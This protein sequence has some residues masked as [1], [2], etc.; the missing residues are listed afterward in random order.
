MGCSTVTHNRNLQEPKKIALK[1][2]PEDING[3]NDK[4][5]NSFNQFLKFHGAN[6]KPGYKERPKLNFEIKENKSVRQ[7]G[8]IPLPIA[9]YKSADIFEPKSP[10]TEVQLLASI[11][12]KK[13]AEDSECRLE[14]KSFFIPVPADRSFGSDVDDKRFMRFSISFNGAEEVKEL[15]D[16][17]CEAEAIVK[18]YVN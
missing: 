3:I 6:P 11:S 9:S 12:E 16:L 14:E 2:Y 5:A 7:S 4:V 8:I 17:E 1:P 10:G 13:S 15:N 18:K